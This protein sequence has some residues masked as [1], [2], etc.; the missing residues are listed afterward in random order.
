MRLVL[1]SQETSRSPHS[2]TRVLFKK[3][4]FIYLSFLERG[5]GRKKEREKTLMGDRNID[6]LLS[7][8]R[9]DQGRNP[10][11]GYSV[12]TGNQ[13]SEL[14]L[15]GMTPN[16]LNYTGQGT[17]QNLKSSH[18]VLV[19]VQ[20]HIPSKRSQQHIALSRL[21]P[22]EELPLWKQWVEHTHV[23]QGREWSEE[24]L[25]S[26]TQ[27]AGMSSWGPP[28]TKFLKLRAI[29]AYL[30]NPTSQGFSTE[31]IQQMFLD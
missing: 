14:L 26:C 28:P 18:R 13:T 29:H 12:L 21:C 1:G 5:E 4:Y 11:P 19:W 31:N 10:Q 6:W 8:T 22:W 2:A 25:M 3:K 17:H 9:P 16:Q 23:F 15:Y 27:L 7:Y 20:S 30:L 24:P